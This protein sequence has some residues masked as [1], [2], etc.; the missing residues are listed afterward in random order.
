MTDANQLFW[1]LRVLGKVSQ[2]REL[3]ENVAAG[4]LPEADLALMKNSLTRADKGGAAAEKELARLEEGGLFRAGK[5]FQYYYQKALNAYAQGLYTKALESIMQTQGR[6]VDALEE[7]TAHSMRLICLHNLNMDTAKAW[8]DTENALKFHDTAENS[9]LVA[10][11]R[12]TVKVLRLRELFREGRL[13][14]L[15]T[16]SEDAEWSQAG[17]LRAWAAV[18]PFTRMDQAALVRSLD[19]LTLEADFYL[20]DYRLQTLVGR[21]YQGEK[22]VPWGDR[23][24][25]LYLWTWRW[26]ADPSPAHALALTAILTD[27]EGWDGRDVMTF[28]EMH[29]VRNSLEWILTF[30]PQLRARTSALMRRVSAAAKNA[31]PLFTY[32][33]LW[34][35]YVQA[36]NKKT[37]AATKKIIEKHPLHSVAELRFQQATEA[38]TG[39]HPKDSAFLTVETDTGQIYKKGRLAVRSEALAFFLAGLQVQGKLSFAEALSAC[40]GIAPYDEGVH[41]SKI[42]NLTA[43]TRKLLGRGGRLTTKN[44]WIFLELAKNVQIH[45]GAPNGRGRLKL[46]ARAAPAAVKE[47]TRNERSLSVLLK[48]A[49]G[50][51]GKDFTRAD[52]EKALHIPKPTLTRYLQAWIERKWIQ[53]T[54]AGRNVSYRI[55]F[56]ES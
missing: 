36:G 50:L 31:G 45:T 48:E 15:A 6:T 39:R 22:D 25:R 18:L 13:R 9:E 51:R 28:D 34:I 38:M 26:L 14:E 35:K 49:A 7:L 54:G 24:E 30:E 29:M 2:A 42:Q 1:T 19:K 3:L 21:N 41:A 55:T 16:V 32:E 11:T 8:E 4:G 5:P 53:K 43:R 20:R 12:R 47:R 46:P 33:V 44:G 27:L 40:F 52:L 23:C 37:A 56:F 17:Y 10:F